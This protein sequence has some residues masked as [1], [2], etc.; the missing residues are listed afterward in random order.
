[1]IAVLSMTSVAGGTF[2]TY[3]AE[4]RPASQAQLELYGGLLLVLGLVLI[5]TGLPLFRA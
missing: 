2:V 3:W 5:G 4:R 1:M